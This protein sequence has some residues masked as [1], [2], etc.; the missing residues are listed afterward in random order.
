[1]YAR[2]VGDRELTFDFAEGLL[3]DNLLIVDRETRSVWSQLHGQAV[4]GPLKGTPLSVVPSLQTTWGFWKKRYPE[5]RV[6]VLP[7]EKGRPYVYRNRKPGQAATETET[8]HDTSALGLGLSISGEAVF[9]PF[10]ELEQVESPFAMSLG[11]QAVVVHFV[12]DALTAWAESDDGTL[13]P[14]VLAYESGWKDFFP[15]TKVF[16]AQSE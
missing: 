15:A 4:I 11:G 1:M 13:L 10:R 6:M 5:T 16:D 2:R 14:G 3:K 9:F 7:Q 8:E 12:K